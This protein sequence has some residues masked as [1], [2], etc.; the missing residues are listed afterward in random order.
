MTTAWFIMKII[1]VSALSLLNAF[2]TAIL[3][4]VRVE[5]VAALIN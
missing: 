5:K 4:M 3:N 1:C 2:C